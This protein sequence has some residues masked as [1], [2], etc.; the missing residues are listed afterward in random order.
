MRCGQRCPHLRGRRRP[1]RLDALVN[2]PTIL[3]ETWPP[4]RAAYGPGWYRPDVVGG[5]VWVGSMPWP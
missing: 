5:A 3:G 2:A 4:L 1:D